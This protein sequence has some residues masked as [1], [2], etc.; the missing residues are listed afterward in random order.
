MEH[1]KG[2]FLLNKAHNNLGLSFDSWS[3]GQILA[4]HAAWIWP[5]FHLTLSPAMWTSVCRCIPACGAISQQVKNPEARGRKCGFARSS[6]SLVCY[7]LSFAV[8]CF[9][10]LFVVEWQTPKGTTPN[11][12]FCCQVAWM[13]FCWKSSPWM[14]N[15]TWARPRQFTG[16][17]ISKEYPCHSLLCASQFNSTGR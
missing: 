8:F 5:T 10:V 14:G 1:R 3:S 9:G 4:R 11:S 15:G 17:T 2:R 13:W 12:K 16:N 7:W 6:L